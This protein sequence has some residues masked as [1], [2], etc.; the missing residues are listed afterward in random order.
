[1]SAAVWSAKRDI[2]FAVGGRTDVLFLVYVFF[3]LK[4]RIFIM[5]MTSVFIISGLL[6]AANTICFC[7][8]SFRKTKKDI[9]FL[10]MCCNICDF[11]MYLI[12]GAKTGLANAT[13]NI[14][15]NAA[16]S[17]MNSMFFTFIF[18]ILRVVLLIIGYEGIS[19]ILF[20]ILE[21]SSIFILK[22]GTVQQFRIL[23]VIR[24]G[25][26]VIYDWMFATAIV[27]LFTFISFVSCMIAVIKNIP[28]YAKQ[29]KEKL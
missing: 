15:K 28:L 20:I 9:V 3:S 23:T 12:L 25:V 4:G 26:W 8:A 27:A 24:Q 29:Q 22:Y 10:H 16:Y 1:M 2:R 17:K 13:A 7:I 11:L 5:E 14:C 19:T 18:S 6:A 21:I